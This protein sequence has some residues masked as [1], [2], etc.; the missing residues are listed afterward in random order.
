LTP[1]AA[2]IREL[3]SG[4]VPEV[5]AL[6]RRVRGDKLFTQSGVRHE[7]ETEPGRADGARWV[8]VG[9]GVVGYAFAL[10]RWWRAENDGHAWAGVVPAARRHGVGAALWQR[11]EAHL[12]ALGVASVFADVVED[13]QGEAF[14]RAR[15]FE[16][17]RVD[18]VSV[19]DPRTVDLERFGGREE[20]AA[21]RGYRA[22]ALDAVRDLHALYELDLEAADDEPGGTSPHTISFAEWQDL[23]LDFPDLHREA[24]A[25]VVHGGLPVSLALLGVDLGSRTARNEGTGTARAHRGRGLA[26][27]AKLATIRWAAAHGIEAILTDNTQENAPM[28]AINGRL[29]YRPLLTRRRFVRRP[30]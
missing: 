15:G 6:L 17:E 3:R 5:A 18:R 20:S 16:V 14:A 1:E 25:V 19:L 4:D 26:T 13:P 30:S 11:V 29:G 9:D 8:A 23:T 2:V 27:L 24:S 10:R 12:A 7:L 28:L 22:V 21:A